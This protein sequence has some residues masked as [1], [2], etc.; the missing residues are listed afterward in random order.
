[1]KFTKM[2]LA[3]SLF[4]GASGLLTGC[5]DD[6]DNGPMGNTDPTNVYDVAAGLADY[7]SLV[8][9]IDKAGLASTLQDPTA[10]YTV[11]APDN[12][13]FAALLNAIGATGLD[14]VSVAQLTPILLYHVLGV[15]VD[16]AA[17]TAAA[18]SGAT[19]SAL[20]GTIQLGLSGGN[21][22]LDGVALVE[23]PDAVVTDNGII[24]GIDAVLL[25]SITDVVASDGNFSS[26][27]TALTVADT[28]G[29]DPQFVATLDDDSGSFTVFAPTDAAFA[30]LVSALS[31][32]NTGIDGLGDFAAYQLIPVLT[33]HVVAGAAVTSDQV[34]DGDITTLG[35]T[36]VASTNGGVS[37][38]GANVTTAAFLASNGVIHVI[39][40]V[41]VPSITDVVTTLPQL[42]SLAGA[43]IAADSAAGTTPKVAPALD[44]PAASGSYTLFAPD[45]AAF[46][47][48]NAP[49]GQTLTNVLLYHVLNEAT[50]IYAADAL[51]LATPTAFDTLLGQQ[52]V[53]AGGS[54]VVVDD[55]GSM[56]NAD[57]TFANYFTSNGVIHVVNK[58]LL[59]GS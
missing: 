48:I 55:A 11:F 50:P 56:E 12:D 34:T 29:S 25:P 36:V 3:M 37:I 8:A 42:A 2:L 54:S 6:D 52:V 16:G 44:A 30:A 19:I 10:S 15:E 18:T 41:L 4:L 40:A 57:V 1:M 17:A 24:H 20:G 49:S 23:A 45:N 58:V 9:A 51:G 28:D 27:A 39:D 31:G 13:A 26:L 21:I 5:D 59:P 14:D 35:G 33:Y 32:G 22:E 46:G 47:A 7:S 38:D 53:V 43:V